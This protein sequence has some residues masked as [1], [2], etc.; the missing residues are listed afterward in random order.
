MP[1][2][3]RNRERAAACSSSLRLHHIATSFSGP[4]RCPSIAIR[5][6][7]TWPPRP[8]GPALAELGPGADRPPALSRRLGWQELPWHL[9]RYHAAAVRS[10]LADNR[11]PSTANTYRSALRGVMRECWRLG[12]LEYEELA[13]ILAVEWVRGS[14]LVRGRALSRGELGA[15]FGNLVGQDGAAARRDAALVALLYASCGCRTPSRGLGPTAGATWTEA[16]AGCWCGARATRSARSGSATRH[17]R[18]RATSPNR[19]RCCGSG[20]GSTR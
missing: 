12:Y 11:P 1:L 9:V 4:T 17:C 3:R 10:W 20:H 5:P 7:S 13:Q 14:R 2:R 8:P 16:R 6:W 15:V 19:P 18:R